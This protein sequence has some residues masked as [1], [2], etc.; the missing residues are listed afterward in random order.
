MIRALRAYPTLLRIGLSEMVAYRTEFLVWTLTTNMP[1]IMLAVW[2][3]VAREAPVGRFGTSEFAAY[4]LATMAVRLLAG[5]WVFWELN[6]EVR[7]GTL[8]TRMLRP[9]HPLL[10]HSA[11]QASALPLRAVVVAPIAAVLWHVSQVPLGVAHPGG[12]VAFVASLLGAFVLQFNVMVGLALCALW[13]ESAIGLMEVYLAVSSLLGGYL[14]PLELFPHWAEA[15]GRALPFA[16]TLAFPVELLTGTMGAHE[17]WTG[18][19]QQ[20]AYVVASALALWLM[21]HRGVRRFGAF[22]G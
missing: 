11:L 22:G 8:A 15:L 12:A 5:N 18:L 4:Y 7:N 9:L 10:V 20:W 1:L 16:S 2:H 3:A 14:V 21:W 13:M 19:A 17:V 6:L